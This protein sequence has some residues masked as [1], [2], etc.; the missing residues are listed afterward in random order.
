MAKVEVT[1]IQKLRPE[2]L[3]ISEAEIDR[4][5]TELQMAKAHKA[6]EKERAEREAK[7]AE[8]G[9]RIEQVVDGLKWLHEA[10][11]LSEKVTASYT[12]AGGVFA[13]HLSFRRP[14]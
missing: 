12:T 8:A 6:S 4:R 3:E 11:F 14:R 13:P 7:F 9:T 10:G 2:L 5:I 1:D